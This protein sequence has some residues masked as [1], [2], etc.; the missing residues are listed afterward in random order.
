MIGILFHAYYQ[1]HQRAHMALHN[2]DRNRRNAN[3][4][5][6]TVCVPHANTSL[7][8][9]NS[10]SIQKVSVCEIHDYQTREVTSCSSV[11]SFKHI[12]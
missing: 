4:N 6:Y 3:A 9:I 7:L 2:C 10:P 1:A 12:T 11:A 8:H 5:S